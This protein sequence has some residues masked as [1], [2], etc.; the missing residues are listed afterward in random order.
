MKNK[1]VNDLIFLCVSDFQED[2]KSFVIN[3]TKKTPKGL[4]KVKALI[5]FQNHI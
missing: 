1:D 2:C 5:Q 3:K 4:D